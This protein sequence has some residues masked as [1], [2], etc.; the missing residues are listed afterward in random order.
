[1]NE[2]YKMSISY[3]GENVSI[4]W[5]LFLIIFGSESNAEVVV[6]NIMD[7]SKHMAAVVV[8][9]AKYMA[10]NTS[11]ITKTISIKGTNICAVLVWS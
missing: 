6:L 1:M 4:K 2:A 7:C 5:L 11:S 3:M 10:K 8:K 9:D